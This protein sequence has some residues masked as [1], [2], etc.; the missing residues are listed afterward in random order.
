MDRAGEDDGYEVLD[1][2]RGR[3]TD[4]GS[5]PVALPPLD[6]SEKAGDDGTPP[7]VGLAANRFGRGWTAAVA[8]FVIGLL[9]GGYVWTV[10][11]E[12]A[13]LAA[14]AGQVALV[15]GWFD[16][17]FSPDR[18][19]TRLTVALYNAG[20]REVLVHSARPDGWMAADG[21]AGP[22]TATIP[23]AGWADAEIAAR[24]ACPGPVPRRLH[25]EVRTEQGESS[26]V[27][28]LP[29]EPGSLDQYQWLLC[30]EFDA[31]NFV[32]VT[33]IED[34]SPAGPG[35]LR[36][37]LA[38]LV[39]SPSPDPVEITAVGGSAAGFRAASIG[40]PVSVPGGVEPIVS[41]E[42]EWQIDSCPATHELGELAV[43][44]EFNQNPGATVKALLPDQAIAALGRF[45][46]AECG[47]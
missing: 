34:I 45:A 9:L 4:P 28:T 39:A 7:T 26:V 43:D 47:P 6:L 24:P 37:V 36:M 29:Q 46:A 3:D 10:R 25:T 17:E 27:I 11:N 5:A 42:L 15:A 23:A 32:L 2:G 38:A 41:L 44:V 1:D 19:L 40:P 31:L 20:P 16:A 13:D 8:L 12:A 22:E 33:G 18:E 14:E 35:A 21:P 30:G